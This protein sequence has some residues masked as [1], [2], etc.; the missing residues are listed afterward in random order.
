MLKY[1]KIVFYNKTFK[2]KRGKDGRK[3]ITLDKAYEILGVSPDASD[4]DVKK[5]YRKQAAETHPDAHPDDPYATVKFQLLQEAKAT[6]DEA[7]KNSHN[8]AR[9]EYQNQSTNQNTYSQHNNSSQDN[10]SDSHSSYNNHSYNDTSY[11]NEKNSNGGYSNHTGQSN[12]AKYRSDML[13]FLDEIYSGIKKNNYR[14]IESNA[15]C[16]EIAYK[17]AYGALLRHALECILHDKA[18]EINIIPEGRSSD[19]LLTFIIDNYFVDGKTKDT[20]YDAKSITNKL[21]HIKHFSDSKVTFESCQEFYNQRFK[22]IIESHL[23][24]N[25]KRKQVYLR[26]IYDQL[27]NFNIKNRI[28]STLLLGSV[29]R[30]ILEC[31]VDLW[32]YNQKLLPEDDRIT[33]KDKLYI[34]NEILRNPET[35]RPNYTFGTINNLH[36]IRKAVNQAMHVAPDNVMNISKIRSVLMAHT[37]IL[38]FE[39]EMP[40]DSPT[41][42][43]KERPHW[44]KILIGIFFFPILIPVKIA[45]SNMRTLMKFILIFLL[46]WFYCPFIIFGV[47]NVTDYI[48]E[49]TSTVITIDV[50]EMSN[51]LISGYNNHGYFSK[52]EYCKTVSVKKEEYVVTIKKAMLMKTEYIL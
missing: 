26:K 41:L 39:L 48:K 5:A 32:L 28:T 44:W 9:T 6:I 45:K 52:D 21:T 17:C 19:E 38:D 30:Q 43:A 4:D 13:K 37:N 16:F 25:K 40:T 22:Q 31:I 50:E 23:S 29:M 51:Q 35:G 18:K 2:I 33:I 34:L 7:R 11:N 1:V 14:N 27:E 3:M 49:K 24:S 12:F 15:T 46:I 42:I 8:N 20:F 36:S 47:F 10:S